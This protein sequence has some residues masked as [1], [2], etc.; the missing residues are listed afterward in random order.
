MSF[1]R[2]VGPLVEYLVEYHVETGD[3]LT[4]KVAAMRNERNR[5]LGDGAAVSIRI[6]DPGL[7]AVYPG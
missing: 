7:C 4:V 1:H 3:G 6:V 5:V 2:S